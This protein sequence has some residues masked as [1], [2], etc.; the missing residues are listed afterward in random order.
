MLFSYPLDYLIFLIQKHIRDILPLVIRLHHQKKK[1]QN[2][3]L[4]AHPQ[5]N[6]R[7]FFPFYSHDW[8]HSTLEDLLAFLLHP[9]I[10][11][12]TSIS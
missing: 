7:Q 1:N 2:K 10:N 5:T 8:F 3:A 12:K 11:Q 6:P 4:G 9:P